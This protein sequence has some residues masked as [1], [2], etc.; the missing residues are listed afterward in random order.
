MP[1]ALLP[2]PPPLVKPYAARWFRLNWRTGVGLLLLFSL[3]RFALVLHANVTQSYQVVALIFVAM[4]LLPFL[5]LT[6]PGRRR[7]GLRR[8]VRWW[9]VLLGAAGGVLSCAALFYLTTR[10]FGLGEGNSL[11]YISRT[12]SNVPAVLSEQ[13]RLVYFLIYSGPSLLF[14]PVGEEIFYRGLVHECFAP[15]LGHRRATLVDGAAFALVHLAHF[16]LV[17][18]GG[19]W[20]LLPGPALLWL[21]GLFATCLLFSL[22]RRQSGS[23]LGA[24]VAHALFNLT[25][26]YFIFYHIL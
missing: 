23:V 2:P 9:G 24:M 13:N 11:V 1:S 26:N 15:R 10:C 4:S 8:P 6:R 3:L 14:S 17:Y 25:M 20:R 16:G 22:A 19:G 12:Y 18:A 21:A 5:V 7:I